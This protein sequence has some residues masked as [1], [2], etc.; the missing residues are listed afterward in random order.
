MNNQN[1]E[2]K[3]LTTLAFVIGFAL[4]E[5]YLVLNKMLLVTG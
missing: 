3:A 1:I 4:I 2:D 5:I